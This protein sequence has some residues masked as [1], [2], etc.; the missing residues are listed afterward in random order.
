MTGV[1]QSL[2]EAASA[3]VNRVRQ[4]SELPVAVGFGISTPERVKEVCR[5]A[6]GAVVGCRMVLELEK[7]I[8]ERSL[9]ERIGV[10]TKSFASRASDFAGFV[11]P[12]DS[13]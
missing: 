1:S 10:L 13:E 2:S 4:F 5:Y 12:L 7:H 11:E 9:V 6:D 3:L 8:G